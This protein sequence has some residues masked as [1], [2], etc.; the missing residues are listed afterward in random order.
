MP[1]TAPP[2]P[3][4][5]RPAGD[6]AADFFPGSATLTDPT[7]ALVKSLAAA[8]GIR[9][10]AIRGYGGA[11]SSDALDQAKAL[12]LGLARAEALATEFVVAGVPDRELRLSAEA[13][14][15]GASIR[16]LK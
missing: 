1:I 7:L 9:G 13:A 3:E 6:F 14:G 12:G 15:R 5:P 8:H 10:I 16:L 2:P 11:Q 4:S